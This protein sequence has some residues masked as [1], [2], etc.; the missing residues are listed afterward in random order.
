MYTKTVLTAW[1]VC[2]FVYTVRESVWSRDPSLF[3]FYVLNMTKYYSTIYTLFCFVLIRF[4]F[5]CLFCSFCRIDVIAGRESVII[6]V[7]Y[8]KP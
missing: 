2:L 3:M 1:F 8:T 4:L 7:I 6:N 5:V